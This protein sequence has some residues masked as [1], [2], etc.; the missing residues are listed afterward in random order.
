MN[1][2]ESTTNG[3][4]HRLGVTNST[5]RPIT[6]RMSVMNVADMI[7][8]P[9]IER[10]R[11]VSTS[12]AYTT[13]RLV[14]ESARPADLGLVSVPPGQPV[15]GSECDHERRGKRDRAD[16]DAGPPLAAKLGH[17]DLRAGQERQQHTRERADE[18]EPVG[19]AHREQ[20]S[21]RDAGG[22]LDQRDREAGL[23]RHHARQKNRRRQQRCQG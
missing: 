13:A 21:H 23:D 9:M 12:T 5:D 16:Q 22:Q 20:V 4:T 19:H 8:L 15:A 2:I 14:V 11:P 18:R 7:R 10:L 3:I 6:V 1:A 17:V